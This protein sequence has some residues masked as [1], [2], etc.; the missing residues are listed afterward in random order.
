VFSF[1]ITA[2]RWPGQVFRVVVIVII[3]AVAAQ[4][5]PSAVLPLV[6]GV[7]LGGWLVAGRPAGAV[8]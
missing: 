7:A 5:E 2:R 1:C 4:R 3:A 6:T 8:A